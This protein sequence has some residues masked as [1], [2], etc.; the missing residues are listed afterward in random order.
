MGNTSR[1]ASNPSGKGG[2]ADHPENRHNG[3]WDKDTSV[4]YWYNKLGRMD[5]KE[6]NKFKPA[7]PFQEI[8][9]KRVQA[10]LSTADGELALKN[11]KEITDRTEGRPRQDIDM[12]VS[13]EDAVIIKGFIIPVAPTDFIDKDIEKQAGKEYLK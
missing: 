10:A 5:S 13:S 3:K 2:F 12:N 7:N 6:F 4:S 1:Q 8:A 9:Y 11:T